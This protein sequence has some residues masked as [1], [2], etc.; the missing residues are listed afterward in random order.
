MTDSRGKVLILGAD[1][2]I[3]RHL[4]FGLRDAGW[5][6][7]AS[8]RRPER[9]ARMGFDIL[10]AD[11]TS[12]EAQTKDYWRDKLEDVTHVVNAAGVLHASDATYQAIHVDAPSALYAAMKTARGI[13]ISA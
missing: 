7:L 11:L 12:P 1:G 4:A 6:V 3:G 2:F 5:D 8:A 9:L 13:L 10:K